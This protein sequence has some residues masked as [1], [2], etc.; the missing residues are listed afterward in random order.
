MFKVLIQFI[1]PPVLLVVS[2]LLR[3]IAGKSP[4]LRAA[5]ALLSLWVVPFLV[6]FLPAAW[7][8]G[9]EPIRNI[10][11]ALLELAAV[12]LA[13]IVAFDILLRRFTMNRLVVEA[14]IGMVSAVVLI[15]LLYGLGVNPTGIFATSAVAVAI[16]AFALQDLISSVAGGIVLDL[17]G[18]LKVGDYIRCGEWSGWVESFSLRQTT[19]RDLDGD[20]IIVPNSQ[21]YRAPVRICA[22]LHRRIVSFVMPHGID[23]Q[24]VIETVEFALRASPMEGIA[25]DPPPACTIQEMTV[26][27]V[28]YAITLWVTG[29]GTHD[30]EASAVLTRIGFALDRAGLPCGDFVNV[31]EVKS[32]Q[33]ARK[34]PLTPIELLRRA[35]ILRLLDEKDL[36]RLVSVL[37]RCSFGPGEFIV[38]QSEPGES[39]YFI[40]K[41]KVRILFK[42]SDG[43]ERQVALM[44][45]GDFF[46]EASL[47]TGMARSATVQALSRVECYELHKEAL[48]DFIDSRP[49]LVEDIATVMAQ[50]QMEL[51]ELQEKVDAETVAVREAEERQE[52][53]LSVQRFFGV[54]GSSKPQE[55][56][57]LQSNQPSMPEAQ[58]AEMVK[59]SNPVRPERTEQ[60]AYRVS[61]SS[62]RPASTAFAD[63]ARERATRLLGDRKY[64]EA[65]Q[66]LAEAEAIEK[67]PIEPALKQT[68]R[69]GYKVADPRRVGTVDRAMKI[70][71]RYSKIAAGAGLV[72]GALI[73][74]ALILAVQVTMV[75]KLARCF[76]YKEPVERVRG[77]I[78]SLLAS[79]IPAVL[80]H[81]TALVVSTT[82]IVAGSILYFLFTPVLA[83]AVT[84]AVGRTFV[85]H[86]ESGG[87][88]LTFDAMAFQ[89]Y[90]LREFHLAYGKSNVKNR[91]SL[92]IYA[93]A[94]GP[95]T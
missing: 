6:S 78:L 82:A 77:S 87:T 1:V 55:R 36:K 85:M 84:Q 70:V 41:G 54:K 26:S 7:N 30:A 27:A 49:D 68:K 63:A 35:P 50:R 91:P 14:L 21:L 32:E 81:G 58:R 12:Q 23:S 80:G 18:G 69:E 65:L 22:P 16:V 11:H 39:M 60:A 48:R 75:W 24:E 62:D 46:G 61:P 38:S 59:A 2:F 74:F 76:G 94:A 34:Q 31:I 33:S 88:L 83:Y 93:A 72:P 67:E 8:P 79:G 51:K 73:N 20:A 86:F 9:I 42:A 25:T 57:P 66:A 95:E 45:S 53:M 40:G 5:W 64:S 28:T 52:F 19:I 47:L 37:R 90:F 4:R 17:S 43:N 44:E 10:A 29:P 71:N 3:R 89:D 15:N 13:A 56:P 92:K